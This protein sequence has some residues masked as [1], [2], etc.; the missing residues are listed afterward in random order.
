M[1]ADDPSATLPQAEAGGQASP[2]DP[3]LFESMQVPTGAPRQ[4]SAPASQSE[5]AGERDRQNTRQ[6]RAARPDRRNNELGADLERRVARLEFAEGALARLRVPV[7][8]DAEAG[9]NVATDQD[10]LSLDFDNRLRLARS[11]LECK[12]ESGQSGEI[13]RLLWLSGLQKLLNVDRAVLVRPSISRRGQAIAQTLGLQILDI[14]TVARRESVHAW[15]PE[16]FGQIDGPACV[17]AEKRT[18]TQLKALGHIHAG[19]VAFLRYRSLQAPSYQ[20]LSALVALGNA[21]RR[22]GALPRPTAEI[23]AGHAL[24]TLALAALQDAASWDTLPAEQIKWRIEL[25]LTVGSPDDTHVLSV[26]GA[27]DR[28]MHHVI[29]DL[30]RGYAS[31]GAHRVEVEIPN[32]RDAVTAAPRWLDR[33]LDLVIRLRNLSTVARQLPQT[34]ELVCFDALLGDRAHE[35]AAFDHLFTPEHKSLTTACLRMLTD[36]AG[37]ELTGASRGVV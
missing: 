17:A 18:D 13:D 36:I 24:Q 14:A 12:T 11:L 35:S 32:L 27:A 8:V 26:L 30:H 37:Q 10:V 34:I 28:L 2:G 29:D 7:L 23:L 19:V 15:L 33:Y 31:Q 21:V 9:R 25:A 6:R 4:S 20:S 22:G 5:A 3:T 16:R 1:D